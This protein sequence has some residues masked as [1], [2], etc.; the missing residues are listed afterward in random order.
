[1]DSLQTWC[2]TPS[3]VVVVTLV[4]AVA[5]ASRT[6]VT[7]DIET[8]STS[9][10]TSTGG[11]TGSTDA[12]DT[13]NDTDTTDDETTTE[14]GDPPECVAA[15]DCPGW[16]EQCIDNT[17]QLP[18]SEC[19]SHRECGPFGHCD[20]PD[21]CIGTCVSAGTPPPACPNSPITSPTTRDP[22][23]LPLALSFADVDAD[24]GAELVVA[25]E[26]EFRVYPFGSDVPNVTARAQPTRAILNMIVGEFDGQP[27]DDLL[28]LV[29]GELHR[30]FADGVSG[31]INPIIE[32]FGVMFPTALIAGD[33]DGQN[34]DDLLVVSGDWSVTLEFDD[35]G[36]IPLEFDGPPGVAA[37]EFG[38]A[39]PGLLS[40]V[41]SHAYIFDLAGNL[42]VEDDVGGAT[43][44]LAL[45]SLEGGAYIH[46][47]SGVLNWQF[48]TP[49]DPLT[50]AVGTELLVAGHDV[51]VGDLDGDQ[52][53]ELIAVDA[54]EAAIIFD[55]LGD[56]CLTTVDLG[57]DLDV[58]WPAFAVG[59]HDGDGDDE[60]AIQRVSHV[61]VIDGE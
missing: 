30:Y 54:D 58:A 10:S 9:T 4:L 49:L 47:E 59:D 29:D 42:V 38:S 33:F 35:G 28:L 41:G 18:Q 36:A 11:G 40:L 25:T 7:G 51:V 61:A 44:V 14:T 20:S 46:H 57:Q 31:F 24:G 21:G 6:T 22:L 50:L 15:S 60:V 13:T 43:G 37:F 39:H 26:T 45:R 56:P 12:T 1:M 23:A 52:N 8:S 19:S 48:L 17:C 55:P 2:V 27:G 5:C 34:L 53:D 3:C 32:P 16:C